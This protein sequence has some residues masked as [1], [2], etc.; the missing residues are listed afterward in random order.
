MKR[1]GGARERD[2]FGAKL[3]TT[4]WRPA[5]ISE[6]GPDLFPWP[7]IQDGRYSPGPH[8]FCSL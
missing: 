7:E 3:G 8:I 4:V 2:G 1:G 6:G 5:A